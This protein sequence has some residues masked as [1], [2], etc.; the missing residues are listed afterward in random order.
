MKEKVNPE[1]KILRIRG[2]FTPAL[3]KQ[4]FMI[5]NL[6]GM[7]KNSTSHLFTLPLCKT[8]VSL[9]S[10]WLNHTSL[11]NPFPPPPPYVPFVDPPGGEACQER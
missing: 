8:R 10:F 11:T 4:Y 2:G 7:E 9:I 6:K 1:E 5:T 3:V